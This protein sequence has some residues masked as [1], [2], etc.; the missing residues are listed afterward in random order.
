VWRGCRAGCACTA[1][2]LDSNHVLPNL[3]PSRINASWWRLLSQSLF[4][5][6]AMAPLFVRSSFTHHH[7]HYHRYHQV[8]AA[9]SSLFIPPHS[10]SPAVRDLLPF[11]SPN[12]HS[13]Q[14]LASAPFV[15]AR[16][17]TSICFQASKVELQLHRISQHVS[18][19][20]LC[21]GPGRLVCRCSE[22]PVCRPLLHPGHGCSACRRASRSCALPRHRR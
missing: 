11:I 2:G 18:L 1:L 4:I 3:E 12:S 14:K 21:S 5:N 8:P 10:P 16:S 15:L 9:C 7:H 17:C 20:C 19:H 22:Q 6:R 13:F